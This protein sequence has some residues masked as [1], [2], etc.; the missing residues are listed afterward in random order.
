[1]DLQ[2]RYDELDNIITTLDEL[3]NSIT[4]KIYIE[5]LRGTL[6]QAQKEVL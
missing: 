6:Y 2:E 3:I 4:D 5:Q 1:M